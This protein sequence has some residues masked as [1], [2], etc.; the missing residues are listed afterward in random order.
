M[1]CCVTTTHCCIDIFLKTF[2]IAEFRPQLCKRK[3]KI[4]TRI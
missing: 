3:V 2:G 4:P 1:C